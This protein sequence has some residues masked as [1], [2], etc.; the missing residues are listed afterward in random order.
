MVSS[1]RHFGKTIFV[2]ICVNSHALSNLGSL[3]ILPKRSWK[4]FLLICICTSEIRFSYSTLLKILA[5]MLTKFR[6]IH[7]ITSTQWTKFHQFTCIRTI[8]TVF[9]YR[10]IMKIS[11]FMLTL[12]PPSKFSSGSIFFRSSWST[13]TSFWM[14]RHIFFFSFF[15]LFI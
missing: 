12:F 2:V 8:E 14:T 13:A 6:V 3:T 10:R 4:I 5:F 1:H 9:N 15:F 11:A 7:W